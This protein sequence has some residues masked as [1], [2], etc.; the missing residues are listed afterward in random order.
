MDGNP[1]SDNPNYGKPSM[2]IPCMG[3]Q[4]II[5]FDCATFVTTNP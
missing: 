2:R 1:I 5:M 4:I 3:H